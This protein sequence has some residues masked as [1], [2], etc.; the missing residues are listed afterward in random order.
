MVKEGRSIAQAIA[1]GN[2]HQ[3]TVYRA[4]ESGPRRIVRH[5]DP[6]ECES[7]AEVIERYRGLFGTLSE[8]FTAE[9]SRIAGGSNRGRFIDDVCDVTE[10]LR[11]CCTNKYVPLPQHC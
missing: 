6:P 3:I 7:L 11:K 4:T 5:Y 2:Y 8:G 9:G 1:A 10:H